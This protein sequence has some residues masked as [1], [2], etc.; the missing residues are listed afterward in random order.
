MPVPGGPPP[1][2]QGRPIQWANPVIFTSEPGHSSPA[3][4]TLDTLREIDLRLM[5]KTVRWATLKR[6]RVARLARLNQDDRLQRAQDLEQLPQD[7]A[8]CYLDPRL[9]T[10]LRLARVLAVEAAPQHLDLDW[11]G[12]EAENWWGYAVPGFED[13]VLKHAQDLLER[14]FSPP[15]I[16]SAAQAD[17]ASWKWPVAL[18]SQDVDDNGRQPNFGDDLKL[19]PAP[20]GVGR[21]TGLIL[22]W[23][24]WSSGFQGPPKFSVALNGAGKMVFTIESQMPKFPA[25]LVLP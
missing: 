15:N 14:A 11:F 9:S 4:W 23:K 22:N 19:Q 20:G 7:F 17:H 21:P 16:G 18:T 8:D 1:D 6:I 12:T 25:G 3:L 13:D 24:V 5:D 10:V 2:A